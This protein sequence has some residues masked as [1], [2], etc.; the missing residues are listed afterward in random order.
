MLRL[1]WDRSQG[2]AGTLDGLHGTQLCGRGCSG[3]R[4]RV[5]GFLDS[6][7]AVSS[8]SS[9][10]LLDRSCTAIYPRTR[11]ARESGETAGTVARSNGEIQVSRSK[12]RFH[13]VP[14]LPSPSAAPPRP[15]TYDGHRP[16]KLNTGIWSPP[17]SR[18][19]LS[20]LTRISFLLFHFHLPRTSAWPSPATPRPPWRPAQ[21]PPAFHTS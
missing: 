21:R 8:F 12:S 4:W 20:P 7:R 13:A 6:C 15:S 9:H 10:A 5:S 16:T 1:I 19:P 18:T 11:R 3:G 2:A 17:S 14:R